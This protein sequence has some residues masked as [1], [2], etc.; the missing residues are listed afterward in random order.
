MK[1]PKSVN[2]LIY[3]IKSHFE[4]IDARTSSKIAEISG[5]CQSQIYRNLFRQPKRITKTLF[6]LCDYANIPIEYEI[7]NPDPSTNTK[8]MKALSSV[9]DGTEEHARKISK[10][11]FALKSANV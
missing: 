11:L 9:W 8:L 3:E 6:R 10:L 4:A 7:E 5:I 1:K 2:Q